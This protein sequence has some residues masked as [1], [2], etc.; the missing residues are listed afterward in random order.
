ML[1]LS[2]SGT[3]NLAQYA[4]KEVVTTSVTV[5]SVPA[6]EGFWVGS[7]TKDRLWVQLI[8][9]AGESPYKVRTGD[10]VTFTGRLIKNTPGFARAAGVTSGE[11]KAQLETQGYHIDATTSSVK[12][13]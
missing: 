7:S 9:K 2:G 13:A 6:D 3:G 12:L 8:G 1:P 11:G 10:S 4:G 5:Q